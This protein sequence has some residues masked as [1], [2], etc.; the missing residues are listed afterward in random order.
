MEG[1]SVFDNYTE[2]DRLVLERWPEIIGLIEAHKTAQEHI[3]GALATA[4]ER[5]IR[6]VREQ[7]F[8][9]AMSARD[10]EFNVW[11]PAWYEKRKDEAKVLLTLG[12]FCPIGFRKVDAKYPYL[13]VN[14]YPLDR[15][16]VKAPDRVKFAQ[17]L[18]AA[19][20]DDAR[21]W[22][23]EDID[24]AEHP[25]GLYLRQYDNAG[26]ARLLLEPENLI[27]FGKEH[28]PVLFGLAEIIDSELQKL[29]A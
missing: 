29:G 17:A 25:L 4:G 23:A 6:W 21:T 19:L 13:W 15:F 28:L 14:T 9:G 10:A 18:R 11:R 22:D 3:E 27:A 1:H 12:G 16:K 26:R 2:M 8:E 20:G 7:G 5:L 24:D